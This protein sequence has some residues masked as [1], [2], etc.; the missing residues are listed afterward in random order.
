MAD[1]TLEELKKAMEKEHIMAGET[2]SYYQCGHCQQILVRDFISYGLGQ[3]RTYNPCHCFV[4]DGMK[5][6]KWTRLLKQECVTI[7]GKPTLRDVPDKKPT[8]VLQEEKEEDPCPESV[9][10]ELPTWQL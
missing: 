2:R 1:L 10:H 7:D 8:P 9:L 3:G 5:S 6:G 4:V